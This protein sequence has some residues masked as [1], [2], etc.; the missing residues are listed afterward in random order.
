ML[1]KVSA[2]D[3]FHTYYCAVCGSMCLVL[4]V[5]ME[6]LYRRNSDCAYIVECDKHFHKK[7]LVKGQKMQ[8]V[9]RDAA[10]G[11]LEK[12]YTWHCKECNAQ[13]GYQCF[14][15]GAQQGAFIMS[16]SAQP[17]ELVGGPGT[18]G[19]DEAK[20]AEEKAKRKH[21][22]IRVKWPT[23]EPCI[24]ADAQESELMSKIREIKQ[25]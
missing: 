13:I 21:F 10:E 25:Q 11:G 8:V 18:K 5:P 19:K 22:Y 24:V 2:M 1:A 4:S 15:S 17:D 20:L 6:N 9:R 3:D 23:G 14:E 7:F 12:H 16:N